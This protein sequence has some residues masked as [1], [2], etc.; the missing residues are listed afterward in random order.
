MSTL[1]PI[2]MET[3]VYLSS[4][5]NPSFSNVGQVILSSNHDF[6]IRYSNMGIRI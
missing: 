5:Y 2:D 4:V 3:F 1:N 6:L